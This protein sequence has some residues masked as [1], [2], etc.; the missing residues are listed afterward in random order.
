MIFFLRRLLPRASMLEGRGYKAVAQYRFT[1]A[2]DKSN[3]RAVSL[4]LAPFFLRH[5]CTAPTSAAF[6]RPRLILP[7]WVRPIAAKEALAASRPASQRSL[8]LARSISAR[9]CVGFQRGE[10]LLAVLLIAPC[11]FV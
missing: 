11:R 8:I 5:A 3:C 9:V 7:L 10:P 2:S 6:G 1:V 4:M